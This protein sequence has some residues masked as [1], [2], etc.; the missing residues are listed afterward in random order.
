MICEKCGQS[1]SLAICSNCGFFNSQ[2]D[3]IESAD[4]FESSQKT[5]KSNKKLKSIHLT[6]AWRWTS[7]FGCLHAFGLF[8]LIASILGLFAIFFSVFSVFSLISIANTT[9]LPKYF[10]SSF[11]VLI[12]LAVFFIMSLDLVVDFLKNFALISLS[13]YMKEEDI[14]GKA[15]LSSG[16]DKI[17]DRFLRNACVIRETPSWLK[18]Y[19]FKPIIDF[20]FNTLALLCLGTFS[21]LC[22]Y[23]IDMARVVSEH[24][25]IVRALIYIAV[26]VVLAVILSAPIFIAYIVYTRIMKKVYENKVYKNFY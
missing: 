23:F 14:N 15:Y 20:I 11:A 19:F 22:M 10:F 7:L 18:L 5:S 26:L 24:D 12:S 9:P 2:L 3:E 16:K 25:D 8:V 4:S 1:T 21:S 17:S 13:Q 6:R